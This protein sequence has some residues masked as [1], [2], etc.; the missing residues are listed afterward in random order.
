M[1]TVSFRSVYE[2][3]LRR[4]GMDP[5][6]PAPSDTMMA[7]V[8]HVNERVRYAWRYFEFPELTRI[9]E[10]AFRT[11]WNATRQFYRVGANGNPDELFYI[12]TMKYYVVRSNAVSDPPIGTLPTDTA[13]FN[14]LT[15][16]EAYIELDQVC[17]RPIGDVLSVWNS[18][19]RANGTCPVVVPHRISER[20]I[21]VIGFCG[22]T[23]FVKYRMRPEQFTALPYISDK[24]YVRGDLVYFAATGECYSALTTSVGQ[25][26][27]NS[28]SYWRQCLFPEV[29]SSYVKAAAYADCLME[30]DP[31]QK[32]AGIISSRLSKAGMALAEAD[33]YLER[34]CDAVVAGGN[35]YRYRRFVVS[36]HGYYC[37]CGYVAG[38][39]VTTLTDACESDVGFVPAPSQPQLDWEYH[40]EVNSISSGTGN[41]R[42]VSIPT[43]SKAVNAMVEIVISVGGT[44][45][46]QTW[47]LRPGAASGSDPGQAAPLDYDAVTNNKHWER[48][49]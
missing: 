1:R 17:R 26:P 43:I 46:R 45:Q 33:G 7:I 24:Q 21:E 30:S 14:E 41:D 31:T 2:A 10:R 16:V 15:P 36:R 22:S 9:E 25:V 28:P 35:V 13:F 6:A 12:P 49:G 11:I 18:N 4:H 48:V 38:T 19:P 5:R 42:L 40:P 34:E 3:V 37:R 32:D 20:G 39:A 29:L 23:V 47:R 44:P 27:P 8:E